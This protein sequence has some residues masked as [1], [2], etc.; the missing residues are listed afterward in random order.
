MI[1][2]TAN[3]WQ[4]ILNNL[5]YS[6][7]VAAVRWLMPM[8][9]REACYWGEIKALQDTLPSDLEDWE[10]A[11]FESYGEAAGKLNKEYRIGY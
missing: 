9:I 2:G 7:S 1:P 4:W 8:G 6:L 11:D 10:R 5:W 3:K